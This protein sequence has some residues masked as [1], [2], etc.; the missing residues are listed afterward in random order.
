M[1]G[2][3][4]IKY[5]AL[6]E[7][8]SRDDELAGDS[9]SIQTQKV[10][11]EDY[12]RQ[13]GFLPFE[14]YTDDGW[15]GGN[16]NRP[17]WQRMI[18]D[19]ESGKI[20][21]VI[22]KDM[23][24]VGRE[25]LQTGYYTEIY[26]PQR[27]VRF[28]AISNNI[29]SNDR[30]SGEIA[31][32]LNIMNEY[33]LRDCSR[34]MTQAYRVKGNSGKRLTTTPLYGY[35][36]DPNDKTKWIVD[37]EAAAV[38]RR[39][40]ELV[41]SG[42]G[43]NAIS[44]MLT[45][46][47]IEAP[48]YYMAKRGINTIHK[49]ENLQPYDWHSYTVGQILSKQE[50]IGDTV[51]FRSYKKS[52]KDKKR[53]KNDPKNWLI[54]KNTHEAIIDEQTWNTVQEI[55]KTKRRYN[56]RHE[57]NIMTG[58]V[59]CPDC[60][61]PMYEHRSSHNNK[62]G[63]KEVYERYTCSTHQ[64]SM[65]RLERRCSAHYIGTKVLKQIVLDTIRTVSE[66]AIENPDTFSAKVREICSAKQEASQKDIQQ[67]LKRMTHR[68]DE[69]NALIKKL[70]ESYAF[71]KIPEEQFDLMM[72]DYMKELSEVKAQIAEDEQTLSAMQEDADRADQF[73]AIV[74][75]YTDF[76]ELTGEI[77]NAYI[78][79]IEVH[80]KVKSPGSTKQQVDIYFKFIGAFPIPMPEPTQEEIAAE[81]ERI[82]KA[83]KQRE[84]H[85]RYKAKKTAKA[86]A[87][88]KAE[89]Q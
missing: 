47:R 57:P 49:A 69:I 10:L 20:G 28:I 52:Y 76:A 65:N 64:N 82:R 58:L 75:R 41:L 63:R 2:P 84:Y 22:V 59:Y 42:Y 19:I 73:L 85:Q 3:T 48:G 55:R 37:E 25:Y 35:K 50:Y 24:R 17:S 14:H 7:R 5:T 83:I 38:V 74:R 13:H 51:N 66:Y 54:F 27:D 40:Y 36:R 80:E 34:K 87:Q 79:R 11:L 1:H 33:Y 89:A 62:R 8:L 44:V 78:E 6:Y 46:E 4:E 68:R 70:Y 43:P 29:D 31:P 15:S 67:H 81:Q 45:Q 86:K 18:A 16:F 61:R 32:F 56:E 77:L 12:A 23:S 60:G 72:A 30:N 53:Q 26:F 88:Q 39:I 21:T 71:G 9:S